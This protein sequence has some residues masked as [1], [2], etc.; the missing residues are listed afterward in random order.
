MIQFS[1]DNDLRLNTL[2]THSYRRHVTKTRSAV[3]LSFGTCYIYDHTYVGHM[4][5]NTHSQL[6]TMAGESSFRRVTYMYV[7]EG[8]SIFLWYNWINLTAIYSSTFFN[9]FCLLILYM[10]GETY[11]LKAM[12]NDIFL[13]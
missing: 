1:D 11:S 4:P 7:L 13:I 6:A 9:Q 5:Y 10:S 8:L 3:S 2:N 12:P